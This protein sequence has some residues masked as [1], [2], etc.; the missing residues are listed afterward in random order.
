MGFLPSPETVFRTSLMQFIDAFSVEVVCAYAIR[1]IP[2]PKVAQ[3]RIA[4]KRKAA[5]EVIYSA[6]PAYREDLIRFVS[7]VGE[8]GFSGNFSA[9][10][11]GRHSDYVSSNLVAMLKEDLKRRGYKL[12][13]YVCDDV[14]A[15]K[16]PS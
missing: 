5:E 9:V 15:I 1:P 3:K 14:I 16:E 10:R 2:A 11:Y 12:N 4:K 6:Y 13:E 7:T 8:D